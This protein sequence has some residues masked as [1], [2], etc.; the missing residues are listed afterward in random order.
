MGTMLS[1]LFSENSSTVSLFD[2]SPSHLSHAQLL[3]SSSSSPSKN[4][5]T[6]DKSS[7]QSFIDSLGPSP[8]LFVL[9]VPHGA[10]TENAI[11]E[12][13]KFLKKGD[14]ILDGGNEFY[15]ETERRQKELREMG[16]ELIGC[17][18]SGGYQSA[19]HGPS[20]SPGG[21]KR[22]VEMVMPQLE[23]WAAKDG[24][25]RPCVTVVGPGGAGHYV[26]M[27]HNGI[28]QGMLGV[29]N[30]AWEILFKCLHTPLDELFNIFENWAK[31]GELKNNY[32]LTIGADI[33]QQKKPDSNGH[34]LNEVQDKVVQ[35][36]DNTEGTGVWTLIESA[37]RHVSIPTI[38]ASHYLRI[39]SSNRAERL[40][41]FDLIG[42]SIAGAKKQHVPDSEL[43]DV[44]EDL[45][46]AVYCGFLAAYCQGVNLLAKAN[47]EEKWEVR[48]E[49]VIRIWRNGCIIRCD[50]ISDLLQPVFENDGA[51]V[52]VLTHKTV[53][54]EI[55]RTF[56]A[57]KRTVRRGLEWDA[58]MPS[59]SA[60]ME[61][62]KYC[63]ARQL[64]TQFM[65]A[66]LDYFGAHAFDRKCEGPG[67]VKKGSHHH[68][69]KP[70]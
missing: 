33:C 46:L 57:L 1:F 17:G 21:E 55:Q 22:T 27:I 45:R 40:K 20:L 38:S 62:L 47:M 5:Q 68:E 36:A 69:W 8:R 6:F 67:D 3:L 41:I 11:D 24:D 25:G 61:Y 42:G 66:Q 2:I 54:D 52:N 58:H 60:S 32:L 7:L 14:V 29:L 9:S 15:R 10:P 39:A 63:G 56:P 26:K 31:T 12:I 19:R 18:V 49:D 59:L 34:I 51:L 37:T 16:V 65:E 70:A 64:P 23:K 28:E 4:I 53:A 44:L 43:Q 13:K 50:H 35:D 48:I 30:E